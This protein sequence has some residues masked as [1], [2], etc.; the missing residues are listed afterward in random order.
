MAFCDYLGNCI[1][2]CVV[3]LLVFND[4]IQHWIRPFVIL[5]N[6]SDIICD[7]TG[8]GFSPKT[9]FS[10]CQESNCHKRWRRECV[11]IWIAF[12]SHP[13]HSLLIWVFIILCFYLLLFLSYSEHVLRWVSE[14]LCIWILSWVLLLC[15]AFQTTVMDTDFEI[16]KYIKNIF[17]V[18]LMFGKEQHKKNSVKNLNSSD[19]VML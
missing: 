15:S 6:A 4:L 11:R 2:V 17:K 8:C 18:L 14:C 13:Q 16:S 1:K 3:C 5:L 10:T 19:Y 12:F 7:S 9:C